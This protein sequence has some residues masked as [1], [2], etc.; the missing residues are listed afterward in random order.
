MAGPERLP[1]GQLL[2]EKG[3]IGEKEIQFVLHEQKATGERFGEA[4]TRLGFV[5]PTE[6]AQVLAEQSGLPFIDLRVFIPDSEA[7]AKVP[8]QAASQKKILPLWL[9]EGTLHIAVV[10]PF[11]ASITD[12]LFRITG[13]PC[14][15]HV[16]AEDHLD[17]LIEWHYHLM[18]N[19]PEKVVEESI[20]R[21]RINPETNIDVGKLVDSIL[22]D[23]VSKK[24]TDVHITPSDKSSKVMFR[25]D[26]ILHAAHIFPVGIHNRLVT[27]IKVRAGM[28]ISEQ[29]KPQDGRMSF[30]FIGDIFDV[31]VSTLR[32]NYGENLVM[33]LLPSRGE[34]AFGITD[35]GFEDD[36]LLALKML[37]QRPY[38][39][40]L[41]TGPTGSG[42]TTT[43]YAALREQD[44]I[45]KN[46]MTVED[47]IEYE[48]LMI[49]QTQVNNKAG[50]T[51]ASAVKSFLRQ[52]PDVIL[53]GEIRD[54]E[55]ALLAIRAALTGHLLL[56]T[57][58][59]ND[60]IGA[61]A[62]LMDLGISS[63]LLSSTMVG[64]VAQRLIRRLCPKCKE[65]FKPTKMEL[66]LLKLP[67]DGEYCRPV[68]CPE[69]R[70]TGY[71]GRTVVAEIMKFSKEILKLIATEAPLVEIEEQARKEGFYD[72]KE[73]ATRKVARGET[74]I[75]ELRRVVG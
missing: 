19:P 58:H 64:V 71:S 53:V 63:Y 16:G 8:Y 15:L 74:S 59:T 5:T 45:S 10:D 50:Y 28:D 49:R 39:M 29:R 23:A 36:Q 47:P 54:Q 30:D 40:M 52:D 70:H 33:R 26:G 44:V 35:L 11:D 73:A 12:S 4:L 2:K 24:A 43:L 17:K 37:L 1:I 14:S 41:V 51:F 22:T 60:A 61:L 68:G 66:M 32:A 25:I 56:S 7:L 62:R 3:L 72:L 38:G 27:N 55:T 6:L 34:S 9:E 57:L 75:E 18:E 65:P 46:V 31:R 42:K 69:C 20:G 21:L 48:F 67:E 13:M